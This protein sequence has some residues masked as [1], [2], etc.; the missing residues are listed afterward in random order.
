M[1]IDSD[2]RKI[3]T[4][5]KYHLNALAVLIRTVDERIEDSVV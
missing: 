5:E 2:A 1:K 3:N 4:S